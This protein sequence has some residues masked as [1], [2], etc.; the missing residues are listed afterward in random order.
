MHSPPRPEGASR[1][2]GGVLRGNATGN[3]FRFAD[4]PSG[5]KADNI[6]GV[7]KAVIR[8]Y[9][10]IAD[11]TIAHTHGVQ[12]LNFVKAKVPMNIYLHSV[13]KSLTVLDSSIESKS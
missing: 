7:K 2:T 13:L 3:A 9:T 11:P 5:S 8:L 12:G 1:S 6:I 4:H 10:T